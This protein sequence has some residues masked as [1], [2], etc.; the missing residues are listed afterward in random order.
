MLKQLIML[1]SHLICRVLSVFIDSKS[2]ACESSAYLRLFSLVCPVRDIVT[3]TVT[4]YLGTARNGGRGKGKQKP[5]GL[6]WSGQV[7]L[8]E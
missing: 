4:D 5:P 2:M 8:G 6:V 7:G 3:I 1:L